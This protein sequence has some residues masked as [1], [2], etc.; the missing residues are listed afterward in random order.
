VRW[1]ELKRDDAAFTTLLDDIL[2][3]LDQP[4]A[5]PATAIREFCRYSTAA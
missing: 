4:T 3:I 5:P 1:I 2:L